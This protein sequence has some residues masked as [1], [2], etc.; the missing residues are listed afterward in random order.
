VVKI[1]LY[2][3]GG[4]DSKF[5][6]RFCSRGFGKLLEKAGFVRMPHIVSY[7]GRDQ[8]FNKSFKHAYETKGST[9]YS[10]LLVDSEDPIKDG[11]TAWQ[12]LRSRDGWIVPKGISED[13][14]QLMVTCMETWIMADHAALKDFF[15]S[16]LQ[17]SALLSITNLEQY[18]RHQVQD[19]LEHATRNCGKDKT[20]K[21]G[22]RSFQVLEALHPDTLKQRLPYFKRFI[23]TLDVHL[24]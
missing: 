4:G 13:Q 12:H 18:D 21:K 23:E 6:Q 8:V 15:G 16:E 11:V 24:R 22:K 20:Y 7:G 10:I 1:V 14:A 2:V 3:E 19:A 9:D 17:T 5:T